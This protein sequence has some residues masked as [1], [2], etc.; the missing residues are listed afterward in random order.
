ML[1][2]GEWKSDTQILPMRAVGVGRGTYDPPPDDPLP[3]VAAAEKALEQSPHA[4]MNAAR[5]VS[6]EPSETQPAIPEEE[7]EVEEEKPQPKSS[8]RK[9]KK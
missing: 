2:S 5:K 8:K 1:E 9:S 3:H 6:E 7:T 4:Q